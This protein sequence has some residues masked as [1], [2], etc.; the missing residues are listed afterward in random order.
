MTVNIHSLCAIIFPLTKP[1]PGFLLG[2]CICS[3]EKRECNAKTKTKTVA[4]DV[5]KC[6]SDIKANFCKATFSG[7]VFSTKSTEYWWLVHGFLRGHEGAWCARWL[8]L[9]STAGESD[10]VRGEVMLGQQIQNKLFMGSWLR[11]GLFIFYFLEKSFI[12]FL[13]LY[14]ICSR[15]LTWRYFTSVVDNLIFM[16]LG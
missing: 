9:E 6:P 2:S 5:Y 8:R 1:I 12:F 3:S 11:A 10:V 4:G 16:Q 13:E 14:L 15:A 7:L